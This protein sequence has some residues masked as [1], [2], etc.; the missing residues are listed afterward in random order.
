MLRV[1][2]LAVALVAAASVWPQA[3]RAETIVITIQNLEFMPKEAKAS[4]GDTVQWINK[5]VLL[6]TATARNGNFD[7][8]LGP[9]KTAQVVL[10]KGGE[11]DYYCRLHPN[12]TAHL[13][14]TQD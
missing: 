13:K 8:S 10:M 6:H 12:M 2:C 5:D 3:V 7:V 11:V 9:N 1:S 4:V 14:V